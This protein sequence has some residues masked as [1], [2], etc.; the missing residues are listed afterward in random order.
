MKPRLPR[1][2][3]S[4]VFILVS[5][6]VLLAILLYVFQARFVYYPFKSV[7]FT[8]AAIGLDYEDVALDINEKISIH[9]WF[10]PYEKPRATLLFFHGNGGNISHRLE[11][12][13]IFHD[14]GLSVFIIDYEGYGKS[15]GSPSEKATNRDAMAAWQYLV[16][17]RSI[18]K[19]RIVLFG[20]SLGGA[21]AV[22]LAT[23]E[24]VAAMI[25]E[26][27]FTSVVDMGKHYYPYL[28]VNLLTRYRYLSGKRIADINCPLLVIH[29]PEDEII[30]YH[31]GKKLF[32]LAREPKTFLDIRGGHNEGF[33]LSGNDYTAG[34][35][36]FLERY[37]VH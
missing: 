11:S 13:R 27:T 20:R 23:Q 7:D 18:P 6:W 9:G 8:P 29:S 1:M 22:W 15:D 17:D 21:V 31:L 28:P 14:L 36:R 34:L 12:I 30:P 2:L 26:S 4:I 5:A 32:E 25:L 35:D 37:L 16:N 10:I 24:Q 19:D 3:Q 33:L